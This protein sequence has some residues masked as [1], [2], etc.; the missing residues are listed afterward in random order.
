MEMEVLTTL[1]LSLPLC[2]DISWK[3]MSTSTK[4]FSTL[5]RT[6]VGEFSFP[7]VQNSHISCLEI[8]DFICFRCLISFNAKVSVIRALSLVACTFPRQSHLCLP[9]N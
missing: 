7:F 3:E 8:I 1:S 4:H 2:I 5:I 9:N 6:A